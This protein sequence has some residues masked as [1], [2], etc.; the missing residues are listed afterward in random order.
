MFHLLVN[1]GAQAPTDPHVE[2]FVAATKERSGH[3]AQWVLQASRASDGEL[4][5]RR[6][7]QLEAHAH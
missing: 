5:G 2:A 6:A 4:R 3:D 7:L 1:G